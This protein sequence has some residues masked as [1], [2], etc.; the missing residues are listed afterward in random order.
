MRD[1][2]VNHSALI[3]RDCMSWRPTRRVPLGSMTVCRSPL[4]NPGCSD[5]VSQNDE[6][7]CQ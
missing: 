4:P 1:L 5:P 3:L 6:Y 2:P 7:E